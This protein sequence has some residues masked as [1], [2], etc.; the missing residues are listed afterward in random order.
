M[1]PAAVLIVGVAAVALGCSEPSLEYEISGRVETGDGGPNQPCSLDLY[2]D[3]R[4][5]RLAR[6]P[7]ATGAD[8]GVAIHLPLLAPGEDWH[9]VVRCAGQADVLTPSF[10]LGTGWRQPVPV[11]LGTIKVARAE[12]P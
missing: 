3:G 7:I 6:F 2:L 8:F 1:R 12:S 10:R 9:A 11:M 4:A 5:D